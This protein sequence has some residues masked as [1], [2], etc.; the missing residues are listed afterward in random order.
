MLSRIC[1]YFS[2]S[3]LVLLFALL[4]MSTQDHAQV[5]VSESQATVSNNRDRG[6]KMLDEI[7]SAL[8][9]RYYDKNFR[10]LNIDAKFKEAVAKVKKLETNSQ[11]FRVIAQVVLDL[12]DSHTQF[13]PPNRINRV[14]YGFS[15]QMIGG[16]CFV[17][18]VKKGS[19]AEAKGLKVG[20]QIVG[21]GTITPTRENLWKINYLIYALDPRPTIRIFVL[22]PGR[23]ESEV[24]I[25]ATFKSPKEWQQELQER[26]KKNRENPYK[27]QE[28]NA[29]LIACKLLTFSADKKFID[30]MMDEVS[31]HKKM[32]LDLRGNR[33][34][35]VTT[36]EYLTSYFFDRDVKIAD[37]VMRNKTKE[38]IARARK[39]KTFKGELIVLIDSNSASASEVFSRVVQLEKRGKIVGDVSSGAVM[40][41]ISLGIASARG[42]PDFSTISFFGLNLT[43]ADLIM[44]DGKR[45]E[46]VGVVPD[47]A[48]GPSP[49]ALAEKSDPVLAYA[50]QHFGADLNAVEA[51]KYYFLTKKTEDDDDNDETDNGEDN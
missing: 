39:N 11:I 6:V 28:V 30:K 18:D 32:I 14:E 27:C 10:G 37:F 43:I 33:G 13:Y 34:G 24:F 9:E 3:L 42:V 4:M 36:E 41:S 15:L 45:L 26:R 48:I 21:V 35:F 51:G 31:G 47:I 1:H 2:N 5:F 46:N 19:D 20:D 50:A 38:R 44:S 16:S 22:K 29:D 12:E 23:V 17:M 8:K 49:K 25:N 7:K 40:T